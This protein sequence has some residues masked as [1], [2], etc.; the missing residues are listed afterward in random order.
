MC[1]GAMQS[2]LPTLR[3]NF[4]AIYETAHQFF[5]SGSQIRKQ[6]PSKLAELRNTGQHRSLFRTC[7]TTH[8]RRATRFETTN[9][10]FGTS[11]FG[12]C[13]EGDAEVAVIALVVINDIGDESEVWL[14]EDDFGNGFDLGFGLTGVFVVSTSCAMRLFRI[15][16]GGGFALVLE[17]ARVGDLRITYMSC[18][19]FSFSFSR[20]LVFFVRPTFVQPSSCFWPNDHGFANQI[21]SHWN[22][23]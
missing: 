9:S 6:K 5:P 8:R 20:F 4:R 14:L 21:L 23:K 22:K 12:P 19:S 10:T 15:F 7:S 18:F 16:T 13:F 11:T 2:A 1:A 3:P 17:G